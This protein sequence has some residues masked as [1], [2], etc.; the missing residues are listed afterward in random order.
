RIL[1]AALLDHPGEPGCLLGATTEA[2]GGQPNVRVRV[3]PQPALGLGDE[4]EIHLLHPGFVGMSTRQV[5]RSCDQ[6]IL[7]SWAFDIATGNCRET[8]LIPLT[9]HS[10]DNLVV[11]LDHIG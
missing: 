2:D 9:L 6:A 3:L 7:C 8:P 1:D 11:D 10:T 4:L 5:A